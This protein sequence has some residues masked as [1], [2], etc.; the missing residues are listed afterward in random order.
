[1]T[2]HDLKTRPEYFVAI[3]DGRKTFELRRND[4]DFRVG[5]RLVL[6]EWVDPLVGYTG[7]VETRRV[8][9]KLPMDGYAHFTGLDLGYA[10]LALAP[11]LL[12]E[13]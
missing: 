1:M 3:L 12:D 9:Y 2:T 11:D 5:D 10:V 7:R 8:A 6:R 13:P 4:R